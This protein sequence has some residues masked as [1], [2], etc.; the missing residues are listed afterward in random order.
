MN[1]AE[2]CVEVVLAAAG[3]AVAVVVTDGVLSLTGMLAAAAGVEGSGVGGGAA[4]GAGEGA[5][6][7]AGCRYEVRVR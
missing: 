4:V 2:A 6:V 7:L 1:C 3:R 5:V